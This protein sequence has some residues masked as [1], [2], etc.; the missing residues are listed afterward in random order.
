MPVSVWFARRWVME[1]TNPWVF[2][3]WGA[4]AMVY[5]LTLAIAVDQVNRKTRHLE[6]A[7][8]KERS[9]G[10]KLRQALAEKDACVAAMHEWEQEKKDLEKA[11]RTM[12]ETQQKLNEALRLQGASRQMKPDPPDQATGS[13]SSPP[14]AEHPTPVP[15]D[16]EKLDAYKAGGISGIPPNISAEIIRKA[17]IGRDASGALAEIGKQASG[18]FKMTDFKKAGTQPSRRNS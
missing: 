1:T 17:C 11:V 3:R 16:E 10:S 15:T 6:E 9:S 13:A 8:R 2:I 14:G 5:V 4:A 12:A 18:Y 7:I